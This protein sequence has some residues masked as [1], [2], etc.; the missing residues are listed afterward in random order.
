MPDQL[1]LRGGTTT[2]HNSFTGALRE[3]TVD[4]TKKTLVVHDG[5]SAGGTP[6]MRENGGNAASS[7]QIGSGGVNAFTIDSNQDIT[8]TGASA[9]VVWDKSDNALEFADDAMATFGASAD[10]RIRHNGNNSLIEDMGTGNLQIRGDD[11]HITGTNDE[12]M[13]KF[14]ENGAVELYFN[15]TKVAESLSTGFRV[16][17]QFSVG[18]SV[19]NLEKSGTHHHRIV[20]NDT[21][22]DL[23]FQQSSDN[24]SNTNF[25]TYLRI[26]DG[27]N[28]SLPVDNQKLRL[29][30]SADLQLYHDGTASHIDNGT[31]KIILAGGV[32]YLRPIGTENGLISVANGAVV[33]YH[34]GTSKFETTANGA[35]VNG[36]LNVSTGIHIPDG[37]DSDSS[38]TM[39]NSNDFRLFHDGSDSF[40]KDGGTGSLKIL[41]NQVQIINAA[42]SENI[43][44]FN[45][46]G[47]V[48]LFHNNDIRYTTAGGFGVHY[49]HFSSNAN[50][51]HDLGFSGSRWRNLYLSGSVTSSDKN[52]K[53]TI[54]KSDLG[55]DFIKKLNPVSFKWNK[56]TLDDKTH[57]GLI[58]QEVEETILNMGKK[59]EDFGA[60]DKPTTQEE[61]KDYAV[62]KD[63]STN[64]GLNY[65]E[66]IAPL[67]KAVQEL[68]D[69]VTALE[70]A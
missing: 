28:I 51:S 43:A 34:D 26:N 25:T 15:N 9:N 37:G 2:E 52:E 31:E 57:Y 14:V 58:A 35:S 59:L 19:I 66:L 53:N 68:S 10:L 32:I 48:Q 30:A 62:T 39:G 54:T 47:A 23:G 41:S 49:G 67:I 45:Q 5:A 20:G 27:G 4:T 65:T 33:L 70:A 13:A 38:I 42:N 16:N 63:E 64:M 8:L 55:L 46:D 36:F 6:L 40:I 56:E 17:N 12:L 50:G 1:Q 69:K 3:V 24:G 22:G 11:V 29:G 7:V 61:G 60:V 21:G 18:E 44:N